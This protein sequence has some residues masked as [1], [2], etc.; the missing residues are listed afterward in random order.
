MKKLFTTSEYKR[1]NLKKSLDAMKKQKRRKAK[2]G[3]SGTSE[4][5]NNSTN[6]R[7]NNRPRIIPPK[8]FQLIAP[9]DF[10]LINNSEATI[11]YFN[12]AHAQLKKNNR[13]LF[14]ISKI[15]TLTTDAI[16]VQIAKIKDAKFHLNNNIIGNEPDDENLKKLF[17]Q[18][19]FYDYVNTR[20]PK[21]TTDKNLLIHEITNNKVE[22]DIAKTACLLGLKHTFKNEAIF[23]PL[24]DILIE[25][26]QNTNNHAGTTRGIYDWWLHVYT[27]PDSSKTSYTFLDLG[28]GIFESLPVQSFKRDFL[29]LLG[30]K[31][32][33]DLVP[34]LFA[35]EIKS[36]TARPERGKGIP[37]VFECSQNKT[38]ETFILISNDIYADLKTK[39]YR[40]IKT[41]FEGTLFYWEINNK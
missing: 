3:Y 6:S 37:Q 7:R 34:K 24:Y 36:R 39:N 15:K 27:H 5:N 4:T 25:V 19:G 40:L 9:E 8:I 1:R 13:I 31:S 29:E 32:N 38:F 22:P 17:V 16:A 35:G 10:S 30:L 18:S 21:P 33:L 41:Q 23:E 12:L 2:K 14:D 20:G 26:M 28:V 11:E